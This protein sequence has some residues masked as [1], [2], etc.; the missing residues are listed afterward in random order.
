MSQSVAPPRPLE[1]VA[2]ALLTLAL[3]M[4]TFM[5]VLDTTIANVAIPTIAGNLGH[6]LI[7]RGECYLLAPDWMAGQALWRSEAVSLVHCPVCHCLLALWYGPESGV[8]DSISGAARTGGWTHDPSVS[9]SVAE[10]LP[11]EEAGNGAFA[12]VD[13]CDCGTDLWPHPG[14]LDQR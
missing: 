12:L 4:A 3:S 5:Q 7:R 13:D 9:E 2:L 1:G 14:R 11:A 10:Q 6:H 8:V